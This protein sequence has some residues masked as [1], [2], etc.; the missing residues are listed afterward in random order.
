MQQKERDLHIVGV[1]LNYT[2]GARLLDLVGIPP[3]R[4]REKIVALASCEGD[5]K[6]A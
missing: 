1:C 2:A 4:Q 3:R 5:E 6:R